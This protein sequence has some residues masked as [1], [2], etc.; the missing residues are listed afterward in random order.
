MCSSPERP[1]RED[2]NLAH[3]GWNGHAVSRS[4]L[5]LSRGWFLFLCVAAPAGAMLLA[6]MLVSS[7]IGEKALWFD[8]SLSVWRA[9]MDWPGLWA[10]VT[11][12]QANM[13]LYYLLLHG[14]ITVFGAAEG[15]VRG[16]SAAIAVATVPVVFAL[17]YRLF[18][19]RAALAAAFLLAINGFFVRYAQ[20][21]RGYSLLL[22]L[23]SVAMLTF[24]RAL[25]R[26]DRASRWVAYAVTASLALYAHLFASLALLAQVVAILLQWRQPWPWRRL[27]VT[28]S[29]IA[30]LTLPLG[31]FILFG[32]VGQI[33]WIPAPRAYDYLLVARA[34]AGGQSWTL[35]ALYA[36]CCVA[37]LIIGAT[38]GRE[39]PHD[40]VG[41]A[42]VLVGAWLLIPIA[43]VA[44]VS[45]GKPVLQSRYLIV[46]L[47]A[48][49]LLAGYAVE[50]LR[51]R[52]L[53]WAAFVTVMFLSFVS[54]KQ[55]YEAPDRQ[56]W[57]RAVDYVLSAAEP[58]DAVGF[59]VY[60]ARVPFAYYADRLG[61]GR[62]DVD[63]VDLA[64]GPWI[65][66]NLQPQPSSET[67][68]GS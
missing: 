33:D 15:A 9:A 3:A 56:F 28:W 53:A 26:P 2:G 17:G 66:G 27:M 45:I 4:D 63:L 68:C 13:G 37:A 36:A 55:W 18:G 6:T 16:L 58:G 41:S 24:V 39:R 48:L 40:P 50:R 65:A 67:V 34:I 30:L 54:V 23:T 46:V 29:S 10:E 59:Y 19:E 11:S 47:P 32:D 42:A 43:V 62:T 31:A 52:P 44:L 64:S 57:R 20:E 5:R 49:V 60:S 12:T 35:L 7:H 61:A 51:P 8:E 38:S 21:A 22:L 14:W 1:A 25:D